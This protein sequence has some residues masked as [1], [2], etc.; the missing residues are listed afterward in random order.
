MLPVDDDVLLNV[1]VMVGGNDSVALVTLSDTLLDEAFVSVA[2]SEFE[3]RNETVMD[4][5]WLLD[6]EILVE[7]FAVIVMERSLVWV[8]SVGEIEGGAVPVTFAVEVPDGLCV[9][10]VVSEAVNVVD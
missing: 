9:R 4:F 1:M 5:V 6:S 3:E 8:P 7:V 2:D 10:V